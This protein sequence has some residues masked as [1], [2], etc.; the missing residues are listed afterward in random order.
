MWS[1]NHVRSKSFVWLLVRPMF[2]LEPPQTAEP[3]F[4]LCVCVC[5]EP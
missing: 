1:E 5:V 3:L 2:P 4:K